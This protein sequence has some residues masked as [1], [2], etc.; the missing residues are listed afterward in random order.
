MEELFSIMFSLYKKYV[1]AEDCRQS[2]LNIYKICK[3]CISHVYAAGKVKTKNKAIVRLIT[4]NYDNK[5]M[6]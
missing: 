6:L 3:A 2:N 1:R 5:L 4:K